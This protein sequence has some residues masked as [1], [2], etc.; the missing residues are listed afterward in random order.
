MSFIYKTLMLVAMFMSLNSHAQIIYPDIIYSS[1]EKLDDVLYPALTPLFEGYL[2]V[3]ELHSIWY[4]EY[5]NPKGTP[6][7]FLHGGPGAGTSQISHRYFNPDKYRI[8][9]FDQRGAPKSL[10]LAELK[11][12]NT[13]LLIQDI[14]TLRKHLK[15]DKWL[16]FGGSWGS[17]LAMLYGESHP[18]RCLG[19]ILRGVFTA[20]DD[21]VNQL[22]L[23]MQDILPDHFEKAMSLLSESEKKDIIGSF[24]KRLNDKNPE[25]QIEAASAFMIYDTIAAKLFSKLEKVTEEVLKDPNH[26]LA[27]AKIFTHYSV[28]HFFL[29]KNQIVNNLNKI[30]HLPMITVQGRYD[31]ICRPK[32]AYSV[33]KKWPNSK[34]VMVHDAGHSASEI[35]IA[36]H[37]RSAC[38]EFIIK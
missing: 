23:G 30:N 25:V 16:V 34:L 13:N 3:S 2:K 28:N 29:K 17:A 11:E 7:I 36:K 6:V 18:E 24:Y 35:S 22:W 27:C 15:V 8:I 38:D 31:L 10:P 19:F 20:T 32:I 5:G 1:N 9:V 14:E 33:Y 4:S 26:A 37:L 12:N 21:E